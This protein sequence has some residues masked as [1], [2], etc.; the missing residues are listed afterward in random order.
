MLSVQKLTTIVY[1]YET[2]EAKCT[3]YIPC[4]GFELRNSTEANIDARHLTIDS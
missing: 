2:G 4:L 1:V 3:T